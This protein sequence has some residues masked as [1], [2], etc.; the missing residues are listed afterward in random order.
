MVN[1]GVSVGMPSRWIFGTP[2]PNDPLAE[3]SVKQGVPLEPH[4]YQKFV[5]LAAGHGLGSRMP[6][7]KMRSPRSLSRIPTSA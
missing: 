5:K 3:P 7:L 2:I 4:E 6:L 1:Q